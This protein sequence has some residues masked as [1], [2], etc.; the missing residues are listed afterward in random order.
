MSSLSDQR[1]AALRERMSATGTDLVAIGPST[2]DTMKSAE[3]TTAGRDSV[4][5]PVGVA[6]A[7]SVPVAILAF[8]LW[9]RMQVLTFRVWTAYISS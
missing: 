6:R 7:E 9:S 1:L 3:S 5:A 2:T 4:L 8:L